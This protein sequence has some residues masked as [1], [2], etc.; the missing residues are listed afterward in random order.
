[1]LILFPPTS[2][3]ARRDGIVPAK[4]TAKLRLENRA[5]GKH[6]TVV[7]GLPK[8]AAYLDELLGALKKAC[9]TGGRAGE[10][11]LELQGR[12]ARP[13]A[14]SARAPGPR[15]QGLNFRARSAPATARVYEDFG[16]TLRY[17]SLTARS[18]KKILGK[19][20]LK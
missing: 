9:G 11:S 3:C 10:G 19:A 14:G 12:S 7:D 16:P 17:I 6:V 8:N 20:I 1:M 18:V 15:G 2:G 4:V 5:S 13:A